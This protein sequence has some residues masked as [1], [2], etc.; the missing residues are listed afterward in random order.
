MS[1]VKVLEKDEN[2]QNS[3]DGILAEK[4]TRNMEHNYFLSM[5]WVI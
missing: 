2:N 5:L 1:A 4:Q 3:F